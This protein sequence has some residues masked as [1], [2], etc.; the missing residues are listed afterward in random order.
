MKK[1]FEKNKI[2]E[3]EKRKEKI[4]E[5]KE[6]YRYILESNKKHIEG[7]EDCNCIYNILYYFYMFNMIRMLFIF[8]L[9][10]LLFLLNSYKWTKERGEEKRR[11]VI[12]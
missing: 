5:Q 9:F 8:L 1:R 2:D 4:S 7:K 12:W 10:I 3:L 11:R 6:L